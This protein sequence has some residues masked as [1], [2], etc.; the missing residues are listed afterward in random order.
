MMYEDYKRK[1][2]EKNPELKAEYEALRPEHEL[3]LAMIKARNELGITQ[4]EL[5]KR[6][7]VTQADISRIETGTREP[8]MKTMKRIAKGLGMQLHIELVPVQT[9]A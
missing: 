6:S 1:S 8:S 7:G 3:N 2:F 4:A 9:K 5:A